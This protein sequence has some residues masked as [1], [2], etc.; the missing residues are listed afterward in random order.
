MAKQAAND[1]Q[2]EDM[3]RPAL[4]RTVEYV[5]DRILE[6][7]EQKIGTVVYSK[8]EPAVYDRS[9]EFMEAWA[10][11]IKAQ[12]SFS[13]GVTGEFYYNPSKMHVG[14]TDYASSDYGQHIGVSGK[15]Y[16]ADAR[17]YLADI[18]YQGLA[19]SVFGHGYW[20]KKRDAFNALV[21]YVGTVNFDKWFMA[22]AAKAGLPIQRV[23]GNKLTYEYN[24]K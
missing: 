14:S 24:K 19:G 17:G 22:G 10:A 23:T 7:N 9:Y 3:F 12:N 2:L 16:G 21:R 5:L 8:N 6:A 1:A 13:E 18:I 11:D 15:Y 4:K 20:T